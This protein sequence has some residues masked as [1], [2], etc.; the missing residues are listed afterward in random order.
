MIEFLNKEPN[1]KIYFKPWYGA[2]EF[3]NRKPD[4]AYGWENV[5]LDC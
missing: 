3:I 2:Q 5:L 4:I 1:A